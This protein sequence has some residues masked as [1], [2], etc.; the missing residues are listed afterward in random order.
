MYIFVIQLLSRFFFKYSLFFFVKYC[1]LV[2]WVKRA[3]M[4]CIFNFII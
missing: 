4:T 1:I 3:A 2:F